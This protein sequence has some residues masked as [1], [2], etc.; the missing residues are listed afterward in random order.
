MGGNIGIS[1]AKFKLAGRKSKKAQSPV[2]GL[3]CMILVISG[4]ALVMLFLYY[5]MKY[6]A[7]S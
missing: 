4:L 5:V 6:S 2:G 3:P 1:M 7:T